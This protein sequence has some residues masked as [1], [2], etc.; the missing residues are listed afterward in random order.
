MK[1]GRNVTRWERTKDVEVVAVIAERNHASHPR[2]RCN[3]CGRALG[4]H[5]PVVIVGVKFSEG[6]GSGAALCCDCGEEAKQEVA[7]RA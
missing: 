6:G 5:L 1:L 7:Q 2:Q 4:D 3:G